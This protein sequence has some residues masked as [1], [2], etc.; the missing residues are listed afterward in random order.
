M[1]LT[2]CLLSLLVNF[3]L[4]WCVVLSVSVECGDCVRGGGGTSRQHMVKY[5]G[6]FPSV[7]LV[8]QSL[9]SASCDIFL[10]TMVPSLS[11]TVGP[12]RYHGSC[13]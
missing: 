4:M 8:G 11:P 6:T 1:V 7:S 13:T 10:G 2:W 3:F 9:T 5:H 12:S